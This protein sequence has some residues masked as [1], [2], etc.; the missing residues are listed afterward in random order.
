MRTAYCPHFCFI[1]MLVTEKT[2]LN[3]EYTVSLLRLQ[4]V[5]RVLLLDILG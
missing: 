1:P 4:I 2:N 5:V 3:K